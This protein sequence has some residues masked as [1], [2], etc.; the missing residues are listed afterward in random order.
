MSVPPIPSEGSAAASEGLNPRAP[1]GQ[2]K[3]LG[4]EG[5]VYIEHDHHEL[6]F[7]K[8]Y[9]FSVD[10]KMIGLQFMF[11][12][13]VMLGLG[14]ALAMAIRW[15]L[16]WP[17]TEVPVIGELLFPATGGAMSPEFYTMLFTMHASV[18]IFLV[19]IPIL[20]G[21]FGNFL[22]PCLLYTS[23]SPRD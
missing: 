14:G 8:K 20:A 4:A 17:W 5:T 19:I 9:I 12:G 23:P 21:A 1:E 2:R 16:A 6:S 10:H 15:Q 22:I 18:M 3:G 11:T 13:L 7:I